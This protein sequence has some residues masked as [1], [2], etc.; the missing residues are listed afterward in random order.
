MGTARRERRSNDAKKRDS[1]RRLR[2]DAKLL[3]FSFFS[4]G[5]TQIH[6][7]TS[8]SLLTTPSKLHTHTVLPIGPVI[9]WQ[10]ALFKPRQ[11][12]GEKAPAIVVLCCYPLRRSSGKD[13]GERSQK[14]ISHRP[15]FHFLL[16][17]GGGKGKKC[18]REEEDAVYAD[19]EFF[20]PPYT[21]T[22]QSMHSLCVCLLM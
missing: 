12:Q 17:G 1:F 20:R 21:R 2:G 7:A 8:A 16:A 6:T 10:G 18:A 11:Q 5:P 9:E 13:R 15:F 4:F 19:D 22:S 14:W 3:S